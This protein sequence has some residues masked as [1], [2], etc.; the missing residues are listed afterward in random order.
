MRLR[1]RRMSVPS[2]TTSSS[3][4]TVPLRALG[5]ERHRLTQHLDLIGEGQATLGLAHG[6]PAH[7][8]VLVVV[9]GGVAAGGV[10][11][12]VVDAL[13]EALAYLGAGEPVVDLAEL[14]LD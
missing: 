6:E 13:V 4:V 2:A 11:E 3:V 8:V 1:R 7:L 5:E 9:V 10:H 14:A 12:V